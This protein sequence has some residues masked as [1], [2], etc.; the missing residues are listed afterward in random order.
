MDIA[1]QMGIQG[2]VIFEIDPGH[3]GFDG[4]RDFLKDNENSF[5]DTSLN[6][7]EDTVKAGIRKYLHSNMSAIGNGL[8]II[9]AEHGIEDQKR[10]DFI[11][12]DASGKTVLIEC[13]GVADEKAISQARGYLKKFK[14]ELG[15]RAIVVAFRANV[16]CRKLAQKY[17]IELYECDLSFNKV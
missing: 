7:N 10:P 16:N 4:F 8:R 12:K 9:H 1:K 13:K 11:A 2:R 5:T 15:T 6:L 3:L 14:K 17:N